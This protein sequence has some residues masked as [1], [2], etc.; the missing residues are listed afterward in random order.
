MKKVNVTG[1]ISQ[2][3]FRRG[4]TMFA[5][6]IGTIVKIKVS[7]ESGEIIGRAQYRSGVDQY[8]IRYKCGDGRAVESWWQIDAIEAI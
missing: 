5:L 1:C 2:S 6:E 4:K 3:L 7:G 8:L